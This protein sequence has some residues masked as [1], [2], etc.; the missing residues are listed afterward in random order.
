[1]INFA[2]YLMRKAKILPPF[3]FNIILGNEAGKQV[4][5][6]S[7]GAALSQLPADS[8]W[9]LG[10]IGTQQLPANSIAI[11]LGGG[12]RVGIE[13]NIYQ[14]ASRTELA[15]NAS[16]LRRIHTLME[17]HDRALMPPSVFGGL[18]FYNAKKRIEATI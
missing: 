18:G 12:V 3:Y 15:T 7:I 9:A 2:H 13:D 6:P 5:A 16:L 4:D 14:D 1:M 11:A 10:G 8:F 17:I